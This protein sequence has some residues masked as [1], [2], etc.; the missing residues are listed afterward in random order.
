MTSQLLQEACVC[1]C[2]LPNFFLPDKRKSKL[3]LRDCRNFRI[4]Y[5]VSVNG[6]E[7]KQKKQMP[8]SDPQKFQILYFYCFKI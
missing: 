2:V 6:H 1:E 4:V 7:S 3:S 5:R 8:E